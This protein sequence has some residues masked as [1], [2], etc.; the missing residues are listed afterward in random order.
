MIFSSS[1]LSSVRYN[2]KDSVILVT[3]IKYNWL[4]SICLMTLGYQ[5]KCMRQKETVSHIN[6]YLTNL[7]EQAEDVKKKQ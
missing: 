2:T 4:T 6:T 5:Y 3:N 1:I 7:L